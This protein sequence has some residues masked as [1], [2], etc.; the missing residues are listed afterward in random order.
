MASVDGVKRFLTAQRAE[1]AFPA[2]D[3]F[4]E[5]RL[6]PADPPRVPNRVR[7]GIV[8]TLG[9]IGFAVVLGAGSVVWSS[10]R[11]AV[12]QVIDSAPSNSSQAVVSEESREL[13]IHISGEV[14]RPGII[15]LPEGSRVIDA[16]DR[17]GGHT[18]LAALD[19]INLARFV[20]DGEHLT[21]PAEGEVAALSEESNALI[22][23]S[24]ASEQELQDLPG[25]GPAI[26][27]RIVSWR[28]ANGPFRHVDDILAVSGIGPA[29][30][31]KFRD[32]VT[33]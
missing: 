23:L 16:V 17:A 13:V 10:T 28:E 7:S 6:E 32:R 24:L 12:E 20:I 31:E 21:I 15:S 2:L 25:V 8:V 11:P 5:S 29:T 33:P 22:S 30:L 14:M 9:A 4:S 18:S 26:A 27:S 3:H 1:W 19:S